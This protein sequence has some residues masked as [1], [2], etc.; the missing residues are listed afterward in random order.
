MQIATLLCMSY[1][2]ETRLG[3]LCNMSQ[4]QSDF[5][6]VHA[7]LCVSDSKGDA[8]QCS[9]KEEEML[10]AEEKSERSQSRNHYPAKRSHT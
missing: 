7:K 6:A 3:A 4:R 1:A 8:M 10:N 5:E 2:E 9:Y